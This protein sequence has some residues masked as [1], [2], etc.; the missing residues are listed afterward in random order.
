MHLPIPEQGR[1]VRASAERHLQL[2]RRSDQLPRLQRLLLAHHAPLAA[3][4]E[5]AQPAAQNDVAEDDAARGA[6]ATPAR[7]YGTLSRLAVRRHDPRWELVR[8]QRTPG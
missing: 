4:P 1:H 2:L 8:Q 7:N 3:L 6:L 5:A